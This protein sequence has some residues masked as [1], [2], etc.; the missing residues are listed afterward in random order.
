MSRRAGHLVARCLASVLA[1]LVGLTVGA[2]AQTF[3]ATLDAGAAAVRYADSL[4]VTAATLSPTLSLLSPAAALS[5][6]GT[7]AQ[8]GRGAWSLQGQLA[9]SAFTPSLGSL[10]AELVGSA[11]GSAHE[12][13]T[14]TGELLARARVH[15]MKRSWG[16]WAGGGGGRTWD[17]DVWRNM[18][19]GDAGIWTRAGAS[20]LVLTAAPAVVDD[21][22]RY[23]DTEL[24]ARWVSPRVEVGG[25]VGAR[26]GRGLPTVAGST[27]AWGSVSATLW[28]R[29]NLALVAGGGSYPVDFTQGYPGGRFIQAG[30][31]MAIGRS[32]APSTSARS[33]DAG[34]DAGSGDGPESAAG[35]VAD[36][37]A[38]RGAGNDVT[39]RV[40]APKARTVEVAGDFTNWVALPLARGADDWWTVTLPMSD[41]THQ[42]SVR[43]DGSAWV[44][45]PGLVTITDESGVSGLLVISP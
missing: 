31:R 10:R 30:L 15:F 37:A 29:A 21:T 45:P 4:E 26:A 5:A 27:R 16:A 13:G 1:A 7:F 44:V 12:D 43:L 42:L 28:L 3:S 38:E 2:H 32:S 8:G 14:R 33:R 22:I 36:F 17:G 25:V 24:A 20:T 41:G 40:R 23:T 19:V 34:A 9:G 6:A 11:G 18:V 39:L 35:A